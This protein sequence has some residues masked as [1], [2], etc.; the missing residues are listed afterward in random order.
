MFSVL[1]VFTV[2]GVGGAGTM[3]SGPQD[4]LPDVQPPR[5][6]GLWARATG[7]WPGTRKG[8]YRNNGW[9]SANGIRS[10]STTKE[11]TMMYWGNGMNGWGYALM[12]LSTVLIWVL[13]IAGI[14]V[15][16]RYLGDH[17][18][19]SP[20]RSPRHSA[21]EQILAER[22]ARGEIDD[23]EYRRALETLRAQDSAR[24]Q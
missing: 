7:P 10:A 13:M 3:A 6:S 24:A 21:A 1:V 17:R 14:V 20:D 18:P 2:G 5:L 22:F 23:D 16:V 12:S 19:E 15:L 11:S 4:R 8:Q 9:R